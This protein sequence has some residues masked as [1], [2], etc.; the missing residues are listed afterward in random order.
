[1]AT[2]GTVTLV[3]NS[4]TSYPFTVV[5]MGTPLATVGGV[6]AVLRDVRCDRPGTRRSLIENR[7]DATEATRWSVLYIGQ[8]E[9][10]RVR[11]EN[12]FLDMGLARIG[13]THL[14]VLG[15]DCESQRRSIEFD[16]VPRY[17]ALITQSGHFS[18]KRLEL[19]ESITI[20]QWSACSTSL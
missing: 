11:F 3:G 16:L 10:L 12:L 7:I 5:P 20:E 19:V 15:A 8:T 6:Y 4:G 2:L 18:R 1:M 14:A 17:A 9:T 13:A